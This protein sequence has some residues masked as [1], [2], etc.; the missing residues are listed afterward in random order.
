VISVGVHTGLLPYRYIVFHPPFFMQIPPYIWSPI[1][2]FLL[3][4]D[5]FSVLFD[6]YLRKW[7]NYCNWHRMIW[8]IANSVHKCGKA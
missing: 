1:T 4:G 3:T 7:H 8:L 5:G 2:S 6:T